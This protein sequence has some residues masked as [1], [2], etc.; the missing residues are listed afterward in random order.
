[1][2]QIHKRLQLD[3]FPSLKS[4]KII[5]NLGTEDNRTNIIIGS[6]SISSYS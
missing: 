3:T 6:G 2:V 5:A 1:M 4:S